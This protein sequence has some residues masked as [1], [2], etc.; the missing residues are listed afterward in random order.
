MAT[1]GLV[2]IHITMLIPEII[3][4][5][6]LPLRG[7]CKNFASNSKSNTTVLIRGFYFRFR[8][9]YSFGGIFVV[10]LTCMLMWYD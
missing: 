5:F 2:V 4:E 8:F 3:N 9:S 7:N 1:T 6:F 10:V